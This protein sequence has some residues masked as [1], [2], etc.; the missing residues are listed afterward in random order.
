M[1]PAFYQKVFER[2][3]AGCHKQCLASVGIVKGDF[4]VSALDVLD[5]GCFF[6]VATVFGVVSNVV[7]VVA[8]NRKGKTIDGEDGYT[9]SDE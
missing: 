8:L 1:S 9:D 6:K 4:A 3:A 7:V 2:P 5:K